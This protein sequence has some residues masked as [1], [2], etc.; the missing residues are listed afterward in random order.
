MRTSSTAASARAQGP[1]VQGTLEGAEIV[2]LSSPSITSAQVE[3]STNLLDLIREAGKKD[4]DLMATRDAALKRQNG[5]SEVNV[6]EEFEV[7]DDLLFYE[8]RWV[9]PNDP[10]LKLRILHKN[11]N[12]K[13][14][15]HFGQFKTAER[16]KQNF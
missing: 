6:A 1:K 14:A 13:V 5:D 2:I 16:M 3:L 7:K 15:G 9:I 8:N 10:A 4:P 12:S 11:Q